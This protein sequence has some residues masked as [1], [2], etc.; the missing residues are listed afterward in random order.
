MNTT[1]SNRQRTSSCDVAIVGG[2][3]AGLLAALACSAYDCTVTV[4]EKLDKVGTSILRSGNGRC[5]FTCNSVAP[6]FYNAPHHVS[7]LFKT[8]Q[9]S[10]SQT[11]LTLFSSLGLLSLCEEGRYYPASKSAASVLAVLRDHAQA[12]GVTFVVNTEVVRIV[13]DEIEGAEKPLTLYEADNTVLGSYDAVIWCGGGSSFERIAYELGLKH[14][15]LV[16]LLTPL[17]CDV[18]FLNDLS[19]VKAH[20]TVSLVD[21]HGHIQAQERGEV[22]L[23]EY[24]LSGIA[25]FNLSRHLSSSGRN[26][27]ILDLVPDLTFEELEAYIEHQ[28]KLR[29]CVNDKPHAFNGLLDGIV[30]PLLGR[31]I[32]ELTQSDGF[33]RVIEELGDQSCFSQRKSLKRK[34]KQKRI[35]QRSRELIPVDTV[36]CD[37]LAALL[38]NLE[39][40][41]FGTTE[42]G[43]SQVVRGGL[44]LHEVN[45]Q[46][47]QVISYPQLYVCGEALDIDGACGGYN[48]SW[49]WLSARGAAY[50]LAHNH[51]LIC[52]KTDLA[53]ALMLDNQ[54]PSSV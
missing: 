50:A 31:R 38:K 29:C 35:S 7:E 36:E 48:L 33:E 17:A 21:G 24:G 11:I 49:A 34:N 22:L 4:Y 3:A 13:A 6:E 43:S 46:T 54:K 5:N 16:P 8:C 25:I 45:P 40:P 15:Q 42:H 30:H 52:K 26:T 28:L 47:G 41:V 14:T 44:D 18:P 1:G 27:L 51:G 2:G 37:A 19:G 20:C 23:R 32:L 53:R 39:I 10:P 12:N 9:D